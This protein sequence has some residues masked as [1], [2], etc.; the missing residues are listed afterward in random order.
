MIESPTICAG[1]VHRFYRTL[2][3]WGI[4]EDVIQEATGLREEELLHYDTRVPF[5]RY[6]ELGRVAPA[7]T[8]RPD[9]GL[10]LGRRACFSNMGIVFLMASNCPTVRQS[11]LHVTQYPELG[12]DAVLEGFEERGKTAEWSEQYLHSAHISRTLIEF[13]AL[14]KLRIL[15]SVIGR[16]FRPI[17]FRFQCPPPPY[18]DEYHRV[19]QAPLLFDQERSAMVFGREHLNCPNPN[20]QPY[21]KEVLVERA[22]RLTK[23]LHDKSTFREKVKATILAHLHTG[24]L[25]ME[26]TAKILNVSSRTVYRKLKEENISYKALLDD[27]QK[28]LARDYLKEGSMSIN[29]ISLLVGFSEASAFHRAFK[30]WYGMSPGRYRH[31]QEKGS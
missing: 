31:R 19:F 14:Q 7:L 27:I 30:R 23:K 16:E 12:N 15:E 5:E 10:V 1:W 3:D 8:N 29:D 17:R 25:H 18:L 4:R 22:D 21:L 11:L 26:T 9:I 6:L 2:V 28:D 20:P 24:M 13:E